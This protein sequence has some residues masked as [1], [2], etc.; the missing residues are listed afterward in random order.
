MTVV[1]SRNQS[2]TRYFMPMFDQPGG[3]FV[4]SER[5]WRSGSGLQEPPA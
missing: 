3:A 2:V 1:M 5:H 4:S